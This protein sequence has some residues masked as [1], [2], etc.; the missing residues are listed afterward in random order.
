[1]ST[2]PEGPGLPVWLQ[3]ALFYTA[4]PVFIRQC[5]RQYGSIVKLK[6]PFDGT[7]VFVAEPGLVKEILTS[8]AHD[9]YTEYSLISPVAGSS[10]IFLLQEQD[11][12]DTRKN[13]FSLFTPGAVESYRDQMSLIAVEEV[14]KWGSGKVRLYDLIHSVSL[15][16]LLQLIFGIGKS[17]TGKKIRDEILKITRVNFISAFLY[18]INHTNPKNKTI[19]SV[20]KLDECIEE[21]IEESR[22]DPTIASRADILARLINVSV[23]GELTNKEI[24]DHLVTLLLAGQDTTANA[25]AWTFHDLIRSEP[26][27]EKAV[28]AARDPRRT[29][30]Q[31]LSAC[32]SETLRRRPVVDSVPRRNIIPFDLGPYHIPANT[33]LLLSLDSALYSR[34]IKS[35]ESDFNPSRFIKEKLAVPSWPFGLGVRRCIGA[36]FAS[37]EAVEVLRAVLQTWELKPYSEKSEHVLT[38]FLTLVPARGARATIKPFGT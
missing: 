16:I 36:K 35:S 27:L 6:L 13:I 5:I 20:N 4:R 33:K 21:V 38:R 22:S 24:R 7:V 29:N 28:E 23:P 18:L 1:M 9:F 25:L 12:L 26:D 11:H 31:F 3:G 17:E 15:E 2:I 14:K 37:I 32:F 30:D 8:P 34:N 19:R 10:S